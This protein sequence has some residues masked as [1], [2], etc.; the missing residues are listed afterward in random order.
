MEELKNWA[1]TLVF[2]SVASL[3]YYFILPSGTVSKTAKSVISVLALCAVCLPLFSVFG[4]NGFSSE[5]FSESAPEPSVPYDYYAAAARQRVEELIAGEIKKYTSVPYE[6][7]IDINIGED[8]SIIIE[9]VRI[10]FSAQPQREDSLRKALFE[11]LGIQ[12]EI[13]VE[14]TDE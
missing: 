3:L 7:E 2:I 9:H 10:I 11:L 8:N 14:S 5:I 13:E 12:P 4:T 1:L 6:T